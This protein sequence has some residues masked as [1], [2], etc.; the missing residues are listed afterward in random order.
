MKQGASV[1]KYPAWLGT[2]TI[3]KQAAEKGKI[4]EKVFNRDGFIL[5]TLGQ[6]VL[7]GYS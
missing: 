5:V 2:P 1:S 7:T 6:M 4:I 3:L